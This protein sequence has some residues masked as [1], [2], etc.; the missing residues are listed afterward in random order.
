MEPPKLEDVQEYGQSKN[1]Q[2]LKKWCYTIWIT[3]GRRRELL[4]I[5][6]QTLIKVCEEESKPG[7]WKRSNICPVRKRSDAFL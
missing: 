3:E 6:H 5:L 1:K 7:D 4:K 2:S